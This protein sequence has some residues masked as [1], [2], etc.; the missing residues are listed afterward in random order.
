MQNSKRGKFS[1]ELRM[2][3]RQVLMSAENEQDLNSWIATLKA[4]IDSEKHMPVAESK[5]FGNV[6]I[7]NRKNHVLCSE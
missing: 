3:E 7:I 4:V 6:S 1:F 5:N 2:Q